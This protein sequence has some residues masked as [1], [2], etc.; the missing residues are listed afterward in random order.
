MIFGFGFASNSKDIEPTFVLADWVPVG[1]EEQGAPKGLA[2]EIVAA[3]NHTLNSSARV[4]ITK[5]PRM[6]RGI[7]NGDFDFTI[8][9]REPKRYSG[10]T[11]LTD[12]GCMRTLLV[13]MKVSPVGSIEALKGKRIA[14][15]G[16]GYFMERYGD[17]LNISAIQTSQSYTMFNMALRG[18]VDAFIVNDAIWQTF[19]NGLYP[20]YKIAPKNW[21][22]FA[23]PIVIETLPMAISIS[24]KSGQHELAKQI[25]TIM[26]NP[27]F[28]SALKT[29]FQRCG[30]TY[31]L[32]CD[33]PIK[34]LP[35]DHTE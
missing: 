34:Y 25:S 6:V 7:N 8:S 35:T 9:Y 14:H 4:V 17:E 12:I 15:P 10:V 22:K 33:Y 32:Q 13:S 19:R 3:L 2:V 24:K 26:D 31:A 23:D 29:I 1:W 20:G 18:R 28:V 21:Q 5:V 16:G 11:F 30:L 27:K